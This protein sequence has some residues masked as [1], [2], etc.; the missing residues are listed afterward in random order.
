MA[1][2]GVEIG[3][4]IDKEVIVTLYTRLGLLRRKLHIPLLLTNFKGKPAREVTYI[5][6]GNIE[7]DRRRFLRVRIKESNLAKGK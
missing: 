5:T 1:D 6:I 4:L 2:T 7:V 3:I